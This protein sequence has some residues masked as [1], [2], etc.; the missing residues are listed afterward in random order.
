MGIY[1]TAVYACSKNG[2]IKQFLK[3]V[4]WGPLDYL[5]VDAPPGTSD[6]HITIA[7]SLKTGPADGALII[8]T[9]QVRMWAGRA[10]A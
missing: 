1:G 5:V 3:D 6:E 2:L 4:E 10:A 9:P 7:Q 8:T